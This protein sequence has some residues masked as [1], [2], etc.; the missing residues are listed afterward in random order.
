MRSPLTKPKET[1]QELSKKFLRVSDLN[2]QIDETEKEIRRLHSKQQ[3][4][5]KKIHH[6]LRDNHRAMEEIDGTQEELMLI[7]DA[8]LKV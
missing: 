2:L 4:D 5:Q 7:Y 1:E 8:A 6:L 3:K